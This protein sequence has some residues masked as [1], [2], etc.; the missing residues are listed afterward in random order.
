VGY[1]QLKTAANKFATIPK[2][3]AR[4][5]GHYIHGTGDEADSPADQVVD[6]VKLHNTMIVFVV[7]NLPF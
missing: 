3:T 7:A 4:F 1:L 6:L 5:S 2:T